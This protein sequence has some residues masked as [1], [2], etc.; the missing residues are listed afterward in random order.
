M[1]EIRQK[2]I[3]VN[4]TILIISIILNI[5][6]QYFSQQNTW[7]K[8][9]EEI[10]EDVTRQK[11]IKEWSNGD[12]TV[13]LSAKVIAPQR[14]VSDGKRLVHIRISSK[15]KGYRNLVLQAI[16][17]PWLNPDRFEKDDLVVFIGRVKLGWLSKTEGETRGR[18][19]RDKPILLELNELLSIVRKDK[20]NILHIYYAD[21]YSYDWI[22]SGKSKDTNEYC[23]VTQGSG[24]KIFRKLD[25][26]SSSQKFL[27]K[28]KK[29]FTQIGY[30]REG[31]IILSSTTGDRDYLDSDSISVFRSLSIS[32][33]LVISGFHLSVVFMMFKF[34]IESILALLTGHR[35]QPQKYPVY[36][37]SAAG[38]IYYACL[39]NISISLVRASSAML[40]V[41]F[42]IL[43]N[44][45][46][47]ILTVFNLVILSL[48]LF[49]PQA[50]M[51]ISTQLSLSAVYGIHV[52]MVLC[53]RYQ[54]EYE[55]E[56]GKV[57][58]KYKRKIELAF[59]AS[60]GA[61]VFTTP[62][63]LYWFNNMVPLGAFINLA[64]VPVYS[65]AVIVMGISALS[66]CFVLDF[67][68]LELATLLL[69]G[70]GYIV[71]IL[72]EVIYYLF[73]FLHLINGLDVQLSE[74]Q[75]KILVICFIFTCISLVISAYYHQ[76]RSAITVNLRDLHNLSISR[77]IKI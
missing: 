67:L 32:H 10:R 75:S 1:K 34:V 54:N 11:V 36:I 25:S 50:L 33:L 57:G 4:L 72:V 74:L 7:E 71:F 48:S 46:I 43:T 56:S 77:K 24:A 12:L 69:K 70:L 5:K 3:T 53:R 65:I 62:V 23:R 66:I 44:R 20:T 60:L 63:L 49:F 14:N 21:K 17:L 26:I 22:C 13:L 73:D 64:V 51:N 58:N 6:G 55:T 8:Y 41:V 39:L 18:Q 38:V 16:D 31:A 42:A 59:S 35:L 9:I 37:L 52:L 2:R 45:K 19:N 40:I 68:H 76:S 61:W 27:E 47:K 29:I 15:Q 30:G 28:I